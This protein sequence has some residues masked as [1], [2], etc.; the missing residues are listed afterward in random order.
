MFHPQLS[1]QTPPTQQVRIS[2]VHVIEEAE[3]DTEHHVDHAEDDGQPHL[4]GVEEVE[5]VLRYLP[6]LLSIKD[7]L[8]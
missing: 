2:S 6:Y 5:L 3:E 4:E 7:V 1:G 8:S